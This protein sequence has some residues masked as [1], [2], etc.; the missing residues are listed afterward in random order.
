MEPNFPSEKADQAL[1]ELQH[2]LPEN[3][4]L[5]TH[6]ERFRASFDNL[7]L[8]FLPQAV[9]QPSRSE[10]I[11]TLLRLANQY[12]IPVT[13]RGAGSSTTGSASPRYGG[14]VLDL[15]GWKQI[16]ID[17]VAGLAEV[18]AGATLQAIQDSA[19]PAGWFFPPDPSSLKFATIGGAIACNAGGMRGAKY[20]VTRDYILGLEGFLPTGE[21]VKWGGPLRKFAAGYNL[22]DL[23]VG[24]EG[25]LGVITKA[26]LRLLPLPETRQTL[27]AEFPDE[28]AALAAVQSIQCARLQPS[29]LEFLDRQTVECTLRSL[30]QST[31]CA[32]RLPGSSCA[33]LLIEVDGRAAVVAQ[34]RAELLAIL[35]QHQARVQT[36]AG[37]EE[38]EQL[39]TIRRRCSQAMFQMGDAKLNEDVV[40]PW[41]ARQSLL[42]FTLELKERYGLPTPTFGHAA[43]GNFHVHFMYHRDNPEECRKAEQAVQA[44]MEKVVAL[45]GAISGEHGIGLAKSPFLPLQHSAPQIQAMQ[46]IKQALDP[47]G[48]LNPGKIFQPFRVWEIAPVKVHLPWDQ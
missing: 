47:R 7:R 21:S 31:P 38:A 40:V 46:A 25:T 1:R 8:S 35:H 48:I 37:T 30:P 32:L 14:W 23:W 17:A 20:G 16:E 4:I 26:I 11:Q 19:A 43:D 27:L 39:W 6:E 45:G 28:A 41:Q 12:R 29:I 13:T 33:L 3:V 22:R 18:Q 2:I 15:S 42:A 9:V 5:L 10:H 36:A 44:L 24:S 34:E